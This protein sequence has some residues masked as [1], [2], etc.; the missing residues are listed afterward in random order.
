MILKIN[1]KNN[2]HVYGDV[3]FHDGLGSE[4]VFS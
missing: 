4:T 1:I 2:R 3:V